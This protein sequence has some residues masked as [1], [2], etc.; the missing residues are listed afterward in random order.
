MVRITAT[1][2]ARRLSKTLDRAEHGRESFVIERNGEPIAELRPAEA[3]KPFTGSEL[4][5]LI[6][7]H[8]PVWGEDEDPLGELMAERERNPYVDK[9][10][11]R[12]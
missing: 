8:R 4:A 2:L 5:D 6:R 11:D 7:R 1:E 9:F 10:A 3:R 12:D